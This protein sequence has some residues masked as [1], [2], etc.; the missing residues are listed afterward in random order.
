MAITV[1]RGSVPL[2][3][4]LEVLF[5]EAIRS[6]LWPLGSRIPTEA[7]L[8]Q[9]YGV[10]RVTVRQAI[11]K[12]VAAGVLGRRQGVGTFVV[13]DLPEAVQTSVLDGDLLNLRAI[14]EQTEAQLITSSHMVPDA[15]VLERLGIPPGTRC[16]QV[17]RTRTLDGWPI[18][19]V[20]N[21]IPEPLAVRL[22]E[23]GLAHG[24]TMDLIERFGK[25][26]VVAADQVISATVSNPRHAR[27]LQTR[28]GD[29][30][31]SVERVMLDED[32]VPLAFVRSLYR[33]DRFRYYT[34]LTRKA[35][36]PRAGEPWATE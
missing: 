32:D 30:L 17:E 16:L 29:P 23:S 7:E 27:I 24:S 3:Y 5:R 26:T 36:L 11:N 15:H 14:A 13:G 35:E 25:V 33:V 2:Y 9:E 4:Q 8:G 28:V 12:L 31:L 10:S 19:F 34:R 6:Q 1:D 18:S 22:P 20:T 21:V